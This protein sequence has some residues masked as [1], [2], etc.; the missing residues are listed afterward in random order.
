[1]DL[2]GLIGL[3]GPLAHVLRLVGK[4]GAARIRACL[5]NKILPPGTTITDLI[6]H[7]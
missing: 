5:S 4:R 1:M 6:L 2:H 7:L 3:S